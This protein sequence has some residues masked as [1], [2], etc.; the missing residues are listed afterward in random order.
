MMRRCLSLCL[1]LLWSAPVLAQESQQSL[2]EV[3]EL[4]RQLILRDIQIT[5]LRAGNLQIEIE[6]AEARLNLRVMAFQATVVA[7]ADVAEGTT[8]NALT[9]EFTQPFVEPPDPAEDGDA[10]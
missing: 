3:R 2:S 4:E 7:E 9:G 10:P 8:Y 5:Q 1:V 6:L